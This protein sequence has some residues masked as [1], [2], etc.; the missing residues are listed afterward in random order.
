M[1]KQRS[2]IVMLRMLVMFLLDLLGIC[3]LLSMSN[4]GEMEFLFYANWLMPLTVA[5]GVLFAG[6]VAYQVLAIVK[7]I[8]TDGHIVTPAMILAVTAFCF[9][10]CLFYKYLIP[11]TIAIASAVGT[12][13]FAVYCL[14]MHIF[15]R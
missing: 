13:L 1:K 5:F 9:F 10:S 2:K 4:N 14:Y 11:L 6:A 3:F 7:K 12:V 8:R 15:Y